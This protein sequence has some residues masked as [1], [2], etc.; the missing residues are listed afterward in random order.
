MGDKVSENYLDN[1]L[2]TVDAKD[3]DDAFLND[4]NGASEDFLR[5]FEN[6]LESEAYSEFLDE[7][8]FDLDEKKSENASVKEPIMHLP[9]DMEDVVPLEEI[10]GQMD[11]EELVSEEPVKE[12]KITEDDGFD[13]FEVDTLDELSSAMSEFEPSV[14]EEYGEPNLAGDTDEDLLNLLGEDSELSDIGELLSDE[15][16]AVSAES[17]SVFDEFAEKEH[18]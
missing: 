11:E 6:E 18:P 13:S 15:E 17:D 4:D 7:F 8:D 9:D 14:V 12:E 1:L 16:G 2:K 10:L 5:E 3:D